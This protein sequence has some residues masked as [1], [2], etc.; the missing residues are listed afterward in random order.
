MN[1]LIFNT[2]LI[3][4]RTNSTIVKIGKL[5]NKKYRYEE[6]LFICNGIKL[7]LEAVKFGATIKYIVL[8]N[9]TKFDNDIIKQIKNCQN[10]GVNILC[11]SEGVYSKLTEEISPQGIITVCSFFDKKHR[12]FTNAENGYFDNKI[13]LFESIRDPGNIGTIIRN[14]AA[15]GVDRLI[16]SQDCVDIYSPKVIRSAMGAVFK[17]NIDIVENFDTA[18]RSL[19]E[20]GKRILS[21]ALGRKS[22]VLGEHKLSN[23]DVIVIGNEGHGISNETLNMSDDTIFIPMQENTESLNAAIAS[24]IFMWELTK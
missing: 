20:S 4:S 2:E 22:L 7:F 13:M 6:K 24:A 14:A 12:F 1:E 5:N 15:F 11:V 16:F 17:M 10:N 9:Q 3:T 18:I 8:N 21:A 19:K 23:N